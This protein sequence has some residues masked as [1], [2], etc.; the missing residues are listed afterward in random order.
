M[1][2]GL[3]VAVV[4]A[5]KVAAAPSLE[6]GWLP[7][8]RAAS[9]VQ[10]GRTD[11]SDTVLPS[12]IIDQSSVAGLVSQRL[13]SATARAAARWTYLPGE[14][15]FNDRLDDLVVNSGGLSARGAMTLSPEGRVGGRVDLPELAGWKNS[16]REYQ[17]V[18]MRVVEGS[19][20]VNDMNLTRF[21]IMYAFGALRPQWACRVANDPSNLTVS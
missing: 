19:S 5:T 14:S 1:V 18:S 2:L 20:I 3:V 16:R 10:V 7:A 11:P 17:G 8:Q 6:P 13:E 21:D 12:G 15:A 9:A 4:L